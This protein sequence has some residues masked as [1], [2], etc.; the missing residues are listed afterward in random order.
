MINPY[1]ELLILLA[2]IN[3]IFSISLN[4]VL[5]FNGQFALGH[6]GFLLIGTYASGVATASLG[7]PLWAGVLLSLALSA[8]GAVI[9]G[10]PSLRLRGDYLAIATLGFGEI[11][12]IVVLTLPKETFGGPTGMRDVVSLGRYLPIPSMMNGVGNF[13]AMLFFMAVLLALVVWGALSFALFV[14]RKLGG[15]RLF[16]WIA[17]GLLVVTAAVLHKQLAKAFLEVFMVGQSFHQAAF[18][19]KQW[20]IFAVFLL[21]VAAVILLVR[22]YLASAP[23]RAVVSIREDE[24]AATN[25]GINVAAVKLRNFIFGGVLAGLAGSLTAH[26]VPLF[27]PADFDFFRSVEVLLMVVLG[28]MGSITGSIIGAIVLT[29]LPEVLRFLE[30]WRLV[31][32]SVVLILF[33]LF[34]P[35][36]LVGNAE[37]SQLLKLKWFGN[38]DRRGMPGST[39]DAEVR[40][41]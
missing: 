15:R 20:G 11:I 33:M 23:G 25:L 27:R 4:L 13:V 2:L 41:A 9:V 3:I 7:W 18:D 26:T 29:V 1:W 12:R 32:Y 6:G 22:N 28:G 36:G 10:Y 35:G 30:Q 31:I 17:L 37:I 19:S 16:R 40:G 38:R 8:V 24:I 39:D 21:I 34:R 5:G 14:E